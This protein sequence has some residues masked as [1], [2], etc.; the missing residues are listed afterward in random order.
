MDFHKTVLHCWLPFPTFNYNDCN[1]DCFLCV[2]PLASIIQT[3]S[4]PPKLNGPTFRHDVVRL[5]VDRSLN[6]IVQM[7]EEL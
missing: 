1:G 2:F 3:P 7:D 6:K 5:G 4:T